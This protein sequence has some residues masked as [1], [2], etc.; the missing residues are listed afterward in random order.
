[1]H[2]LATRIENR[3]AEIAIAFLT[4]LRPRLGAKTGEFCG[5]QSNTKVPRILI[6][7]YCPVDGSFTVIAISLFIFR[8]TLSIFKFLTTE[9]STASPPVKLNTLTTHPCYWLM[10]ARLQFQ[11]ESQSMYSMPTMEAP[12]RGRRSSSGPLLSLQIVQR[13][14][15]VRWQ[16]QTNL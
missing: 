1:M 6:I 9:Y 4:L 5:D 8:P 13:S 14:L 16:F 3:D 7:V 15:C 2:D 10:L 12:L 11:Y